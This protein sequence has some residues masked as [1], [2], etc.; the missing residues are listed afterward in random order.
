M[1]HS[2]KTAQDIL[3]GWHAITLEPSQDARIKTKSLMKQNKGSFIC[4][5][6]LP[7]ACLGLQISTFLT[8]VALVHGP[9]AGSRDRQA[10]LPISCPQKSFFYLMDCGL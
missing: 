9:A 2:V 10:S 8:E 7:I 3:C 6:S 4:T 1:A 5:P